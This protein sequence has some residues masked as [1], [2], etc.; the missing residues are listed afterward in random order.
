MELRL[1]KEAD[2]GTTKDEALRKLHI[3]STRYLIDLYFG[4]SATL[5]GVIYSG[6]RK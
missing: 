5:P 2:E 3:L 1:A 6:N 4:R